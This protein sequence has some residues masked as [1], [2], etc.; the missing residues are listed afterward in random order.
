MN[1][2]IVFL[3]KPHTYIQ[4]TYTTLRGCVP[5]LFVKQS[6]GLCER[7]LTPVRTSP[8]T[9]LAEKIVSLQRGRRD[10]SLRLAGLFEKLETA[11]FKH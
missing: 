1:S 6:H 3:C 4:Q 5:P 7:S 10:A 11:L 8:D 2:S 9:V